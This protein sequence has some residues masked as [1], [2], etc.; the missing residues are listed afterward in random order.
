[1]DSACFSISLAEVLGGQD[2]SACCGLYSLQDSR[3]DI[4]PLVVAR[5]AA[6]SLKASGAPGLQMGLAGAEEEGCSPR[7]KLSTLSLHFLLT[8][9]WPHVHRGG[10][11]WGAERHQGDGL[12]WGWGK[13]GDFLSMEVLEWLG[14]I[15]CVLQGAAQP[16]QVEP[17]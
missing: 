16:P 6:P 5:R 15:Y 17:A 1:M 4:S 13:P 3:K 9:L 14:K 7:G 8:V 2:S 12:D 10:V 11:H